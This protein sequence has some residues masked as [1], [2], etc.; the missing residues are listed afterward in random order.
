MQLFVRIAARFIHANERK[1]S[2]NA[3]KFFQC[4]GYSAYSEYALAL[5]LIDELIAMEHY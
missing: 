2:P 3:G 1:I 5:G 4:L